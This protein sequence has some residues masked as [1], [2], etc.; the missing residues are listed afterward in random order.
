MFRKAITF[1]QD[2]GGWNAVNVN[3]MSYMFNEASEFD[4]DLSGWCVTKITS[5]LI[6]F[7]LYSSLTEPNKPVW[8]T[9]P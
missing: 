1:D 2:I 4:Q 5:E 6:N 3:Y 9:C 7:S 8:G